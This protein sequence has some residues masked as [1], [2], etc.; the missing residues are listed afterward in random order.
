MAKSRGTPDLLHFVAAA[1]RFLSAQPWTRWSEPRL[2]A[3]EIPDENNPVIAF[4]AGRH[5]P[6]FGMVCAFGTEAE[7]MI[8]SD[9]DPWSTDY[10]L[11][12]LYFDRSNTD[13]N[14]RRDMQAA[15]WTQSILPVIAIKSSGK[16]PR[17]AR[18]RERQLVTWVLNAFVKAEANGMLDEVSDSSLDGTVKTLPLIRAAGK[19]Q[20]PV[21]EFTKHSLRPETLA[22]I[23]DSEGA[24]MASRPETRTKSIGTPRNVAVFRDVENTSH[25]PESTQR[26]GIAFEQMDTGLRGLV[27]MEDPRLFVV[28]DLTNDKIV[29]MRPVD[30]ADWKEATSTL[31]DA[32]YCPADDREPV[33]PKSVVFLHEDIDTAFGASLRELGIDCHVDDED[34]DMRRF[35]DQLLEGLAGAVGGQTALAHAPEVVPAPDDLAG[36]KRADAALTQALLQPLPS[37]T[38]R[39]QRKFYG[40]D[41]DPDRVGR[42]NPTVAMSFYEW[43]VFDYRGNARSATLAERFVRNE[44][45]ECWR[46]LIERRSGA[47]PTLARIESIDVGT[48]L[49]IVDVY[50]G[51][52]WT[53][54]DHAMSMSAKVDILVALRVYPVGD[55]HFAMLAGPLLTSHQIDDATRT[56]V[57]EGFD[58]EKG[59]VGAAHLLGRLWSVASTGQA[60]PA[61]LVSAEGDRLCFVKATFHARDP[62]ALTRALDERPDLEFDGESWACFAG[63]TIVSQ[64]ERVLGHIR[65]FDDEVLVETMTEERFETIRSWLEALPGVMHR[66]TTTEDP[67][68]LLRSGGARNRHRDD[69]ASLADIDHQLGLVS[70]TNGGSQPRLV[71]L[72]EVHDSLRR[73]QLAWLDEKIPMF[74]DKTPREMARDPDGRARVA[75]VIRTMRRPGGVSDSYEVPRAEMLRELGLESGFE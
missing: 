11:A 30:G 59:F 8:R 27:R 5:A 47:T 73:Q 51:Q 31:F 36:W 68:D 21:V 62:A 3:F 72:P 23:A 60:L 13:K 69:E 61:R 37:V 50:S 57:A 20:D 34:G 12:N 24:S 2:F 71:D 17:M 74:G 52:R 56:L 19:V 55:F 39:M 41:F 66:E 9:D 54:H 43:R 25:F 75:A 33:L 16:D 28:A 18:R 26:W 63:K 64:P 35:V 44:V 6:T 49:E 45:P 58:P 48:S 10:E 70:E 42:D 53:I 38:P 29:S 65:I 46:I 32:F 67:M 1:K 40:D 4:V 14:Y 15:G 22:R 7:A